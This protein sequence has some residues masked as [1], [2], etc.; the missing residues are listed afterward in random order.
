[1]NVLFKIGIGIS[2]LGVIL[3]YSGGLFQNIFTSDINNSII[4]WLNFINYLQPISPS[5][6][7]T[8]FAALN[9]LISF[10]SSVAVLVM[11]IIIYKLIL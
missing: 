5:L 8:I 11:S 3:I 9:V 2:L 4:Y 10:F 6:P 7:A 1:M